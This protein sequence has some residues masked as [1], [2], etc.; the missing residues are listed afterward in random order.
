MN[1]SLSASLHDIL[2]LIGQ[3]ILVPCQIILLLL[4]VT[5]VWQIGDLLVELLTER[6]KTKGVN[7][8]ALIN[9]LY[10]GSP[11]H[12]LETI[13]ATGL[14]RRQKEALR[15]LIE[16]RHMSRTFLIATAQK[17]LAAEEGR[18]EKTTAVTDLVAKLGPMF[19]LLGTLIPLGPGIVAL[20]QGDTATL[21]K[22]MAIAFD[23]AIAGVSSAA[24][25]YVISNIRK[26]WYDEYLTRFEV[27]MECVLEE[28]APDDQK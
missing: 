15:L 23:T 17:L 5:A 28:V 20:G 11:A 25:S 9:D 13:E 18:Y 7:T 22:S 26:R 27:I 19:G 14:I 12:L 6:R 21:S 24:V 2:H 10:G 8:E 4:I 3:S 16:S 1:F